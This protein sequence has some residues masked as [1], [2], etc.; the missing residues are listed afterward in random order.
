MGRID[1]IRENIISRTIAQEEWW[2]GNIVQSDAVETRPGTPLS[3]PALRQSKKRRE[4]IVQKL[5]D[6][7]SRE[8]S[9][10]EN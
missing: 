4:Q 1:R 6:L 3:R 9:T 10:P 2:E 8:T 5:M 7:T